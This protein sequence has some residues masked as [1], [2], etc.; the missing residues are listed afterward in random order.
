MDDQAIKESRKAQA[1]ADTALKVAKRQADKTRAAEKWLVTTASKPVPPR[2]KKVK[3]EGKE[4][5][6]EVK[7]T[8]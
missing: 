5:K 8:Q 4:K 2:A 3:K 6:E 7:K 1:E